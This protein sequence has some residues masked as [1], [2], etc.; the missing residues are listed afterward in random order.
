MIEKEKIRLEVRK[1]I[2]NCLNAGIDQ[3]QVEWE[4][5]DP[6]GLP[7]YIQESVIAGKENAVTARR[8]RIRAFLVQY[9]L[10]TPAGSSADIL[11][12]AEEKISREF[13]FS[14]REKSNI[15]VPGH[16]I[17]F[18]ELKIEPK[19][20]KDWHRKMFLFTFDVMSG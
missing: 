5:F 6:S 17:N 7:F 15:T 3:L 18:I 14:D 10:R 16:T 4:S 9:D 11:I 12:D 1:K 20:E 8:S 2:L 13:D 19:K